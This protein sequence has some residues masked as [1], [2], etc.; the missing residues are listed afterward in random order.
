MSAILN[1]YAQYGQFG[2]AITSLGDVNNDGFDG[3]YS[4]VII[5]FYV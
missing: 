1:G 2:T 5:N 3:I 4:V